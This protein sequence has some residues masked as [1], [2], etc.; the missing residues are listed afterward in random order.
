MVSGISTVSRKSGDDAGGIVTVIDAGFSG[1][2]LER[3][4]RDFGFADGSFE[5]AR[6]T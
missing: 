2:I 5:P 3:L 6:G 1:D 4:S